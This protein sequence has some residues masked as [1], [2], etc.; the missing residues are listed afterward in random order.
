MFWKK[1]AGIRKV[2]INGRTL[3]GI[4]IGCKI[5]NIYKTIINMAEAG[6]TIIVIST[7]AKFSTYNIIDC[8]VKWYIFL[9]LLAL[10]ETNREEL[11]GSGTKAIRGIHIWI[12]QKK[13]NNRDS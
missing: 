13:G 3:R 8:Y 12:W 10:K 1:M 7:D 4:D 2:F 5:V 6:K 9:E 11:L